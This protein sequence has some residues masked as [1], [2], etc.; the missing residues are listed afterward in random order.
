LLHD[1]GCVPLERI[2][3]A[4]APDRRAAVS[5]RARADRRKSPLADGRRVWAIRYSSARDSRTLFVSEDLDALR[6]LHPE[7]ERLKQLAEG[8]RLIVSEPLADLEG[9]WLEVP[10]STALVIEDGRYEHLPFEPR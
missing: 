6:R 4:A 7:N 8:D 1:P 2:R 9:A 3:R 10:E 5:P